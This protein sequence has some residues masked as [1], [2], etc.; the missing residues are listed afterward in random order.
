MSDLTRYLDLDALT[1][2]RAEAGFK[3]DG[4]FHQMVPVSVENF[5]ANLKGVQALQDFLKTAEDASLVAE[6]NLDLACRTLSRAYPTLSY[7]QFHALPMWQL[8][9]ITKYTQALDGTDAANAEAAKE[10]AANPLREASAP[11]TTV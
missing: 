6:K 1:T 11:E 5:V 4:T 9:T 2:Q 7:E 8:D 10:A 3:L